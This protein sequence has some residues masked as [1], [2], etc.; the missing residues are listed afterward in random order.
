M[1]VMRS[2]G[3]ESSPM[4]WMISGDRAWMSIIEKLRQ[5]VSRMMEVEFNTQLRFGTE[6]KLGRFSSMLKL[7]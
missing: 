7:F 5:Q 3:I 6:Y 4:S 1:L 2:A